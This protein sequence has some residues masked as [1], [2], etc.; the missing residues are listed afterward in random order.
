MC[1]TVPKQKA[2]RGCHFGCFVYLLLLTIGK[3][4]LPSLPLIEFEA[5]PRREREKK[6]RA[7]C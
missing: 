3:A 7:R 4:M 2:A 5:K 1:A 6:R